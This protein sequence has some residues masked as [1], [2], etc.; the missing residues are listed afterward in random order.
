VLGSV[1]AI[2]QV[3]IDAHP[4]ADRAGARMGSSAAAPL[5]LGVRLARDLLRPDRLRPPKAATAQSM[6]EPARDEV[7]AAGLAAHGRDTSKR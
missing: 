5:Q 2:G 1:Q 3:L 7:T 4:A 6:R